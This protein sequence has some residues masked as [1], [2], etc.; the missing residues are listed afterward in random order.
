MN[1]SPAL[2]LLRVACARRDNRV[3]SA[4]PHPTALVPQNILPA[5]SQRESLMSIGVWVADHGISGPGPFQAARDLL[6][7]KPPRE[8]LVAAE[9]SIDENRQVTDI[10]NPII[11]SLCRHPSVLPVQGPPGSGKT[12]TGARMILEAVRNGYRV[13]ITAISHK[14]IS[15]LLQDLCD[16]ARMA[17]FPLQAVQKSND[18]DSCSDTMVVQL[19]DNQKV[20]DV[21]VSRTA[22]VAAGT[23]WLWARQDMAPTVDV[24][25]VDEAGQMSLADV[26]SIS[27]AAT[28]I[29]LLGDP[30]QL[31]QP[32]QGVHPPGVGVSAL[33]HLLDDRSTIEPGKGLFLNES[34][35]MHPKVCTFISE[36]FYDNRLVARAENRTQRLNTNDL[37]D[38]AGLRFV[39]V[40]HFGNQ[41]ESPEE[42]ERIT[43]LIN[44]LLENRVTWTN[45]DGQTLALDLQ[46]I[47]VVAPYNAQV[48]ALSRRLPAGTH[49]GTVDKFQGQGA[50]LVIYSM[51]TSTP[52]DAPRGMEF[53]YSLN[54][55]NVA[56]LFINQ[57]GD[58]QH[59]G[60]PWGADHHRSM[61]KTFQHTIN[62]STHGEDLPEE[63]NRVELDPDVKDH[64]GMPAA[65]IVYLY[66][67][68]SLKMQMY[69][70]EVGRQAMEAAGGTNIQYTNRVPSGSHLMGT[71]RMGNDPKSSV[72]NA[73]NQ[74]HDVKNLFIVDGSSFVTSGAVNPTA[75][76]VALALR[77][78][79]GIWKRRQEWI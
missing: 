57:K 26:L 5:D 40:E 56:V 43:E 8:A 21:L 78:A 52:E 39:P 15:K 13:G 53:L 58:R 70:E 64:F 54:R 14:V 77:T 6:L 30:Q 69:A 49:V 61:R 32:Q 19:R 2:F 31:N 25:F 72:V 50:A 44:N 79:D 68:N 27:P 59:T 73:W 22:Q 18:E 4:V 1:T 62:M 47:L 9:S 48:S 35:R 7:R 36:L 38:G 45:K 76:I 60:V 67:E 29:V 66:G 55:L 51:T 41:T 20:L 37:L 42:V 24:L 75:T 46:E 17:N 63:S 23:S 33:A 28:S 12:F 34:W 65:R 11:L 10:C 71:A 16:V 74:A 3:T